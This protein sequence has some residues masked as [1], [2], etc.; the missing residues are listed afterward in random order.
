MRKSAVLWLVL[1]AIGYAILPWYMVEGGGIFPLTLPPGYPLGNGGSGLA[2]AVAGGRWW[3]LP[4]A[5]PFLLAPAAVP[6]PTDDRRGA[7]LLI[8]A[9]A[10][11]LLLLVAEGF[12]IDH[13]GWST[14][15]L[16]VLFEGPEPRQ[17]GMGSGATLT[18]TAFV[19]LLTQ[20]LARR[21]FCRGD[22]FTTSAIGLIVALIGLF[23]IFPVAEILVSA[24]KDEA[25]RFAPVEFTAKFFDSSIWG[26]GC[27]VGGT[28]CG[29]AW[30]TLLLAVVVGVGTTALGLAFALVAARTAFRFK[31][32]L[33]VMALLPIIT[34]PFVIGLAVILL[35]G[36]AGVVSEFLLSTFDIPPSRW[37]YGLPGVFM[38]QMLA[39]TPIAFMVLIGVVQGV[40]PSL[41]EASQTLRA[42]NW[43]TFATIS[44]PL[45]R[46]GI[47]NAFLLSFAES[48]ADFGNPLVLSGNFDVLSTKIFFAVVGAS[49]D[50]GKAA[51]LAIVLLAFTLGA[52]YAQYRW[53]GRRSYTTVTGKGD[54]GLPMPLP[55]RIKWLC[56]G[57]VIPWV[58][59]TAVIYVTIAIGGFV[60]VMGRDYTPTFQHYLTAFAVQATERGLYFAGVAWNSFW[61]TLEIAVIS[62][63]LTAA[64]GLLTAYLLARQVFAGQRAFEFGTMLSFAIPGTVVGVSYIIAFNVP[65]VE[66]TGT[67]LILV[68]CFVFRNMPVGVRAGIAT[69]SQIDKSLD[70][71]STMLG[72]RS[73]VTVRKVILPLLRPAIIASLVYSV[74]RAMTAVSAVIFL[75]SAEYNMATSYIVGR[76]EAGEFGVAIAYSTVLIVVM[77]VMI[78]VIQAVVGERRLGRRASSEIAIQ[79]AG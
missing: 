18:A 28:N 47:A 50:Q 46:P 12:A 68:I 45:M 78:T 53:V 65:P 77:L 43:T 13:R 16:K 74:V 73:L 23:V 49:H 63:P 31:G 61:T 54:A 21:G 48:M 72:A 37:I 34:P 41:E 39:F 69:M 10:L 25:G 70:E 33:R 36:R 58:V 29:V 1:G 8:A 40:S 9:G 79:G 7:D 35:F 14:A 2:L 11:G 30:N 4:L 52:F 42:R 32:L 57:T 24:F 38:A 51:V 64:V 5:L 15:W 6:R 62:A 56:Y 17:F 27:V 76:V 19:M 20:G 67:G 55:R 66:I 44:L 75:V 59:F 71:A 3:L 22:A 60:R 26:L